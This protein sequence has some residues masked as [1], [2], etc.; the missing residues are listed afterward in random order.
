MSGAASERYLSHLA[1]IDCP[2]TLHETLAPLSKPKTL[3]GRRH[4]GLRF[5]Q[6]DDDQLLQ[7]VAQGQFALNGFR[8][9]D[10]RAGSSAKMAIP[11]RGDGV[12]GR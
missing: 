2:Q 11:S 7:A 6:H 1:T 9:R 12:A 8:N 4:R 5:L 3:D 10:I